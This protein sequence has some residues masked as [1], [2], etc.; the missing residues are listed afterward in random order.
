MNIPLPAISSSVDLVTSLRV[1]RSTILGSILE[2]DK[3]FLFSKASHSGHQLQPVA[4]FP[5]LKRSRHKANQSPSCTAS[6]T[7]LVPYV[8]IRWCLVQHRDD[9]TIQVLAQ[10]QVAV[11]FRH[12]S[13]SVVLYGTPLLPPD[14]FSWNFILVSFNIIWRHI[15][16]CIKI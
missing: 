10:N 6:S 8:F 16:I 5:G 3:L 13:A 1:R 12:G 7:C 15:P 2:R 14:E 9:L 4:V 11:P